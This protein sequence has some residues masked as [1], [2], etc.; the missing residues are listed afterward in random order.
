MSRCQ[1]EQVYRK[2]YLEMRLAYVGAF[3]QFVVQKWSYQLRR[4]RDQFWTGF[5]LNEIERTGFRE[6]LRI[7]VK[8]LNH[9]C[10]FVSQENL[11]DLD[12]VYFPHRV[13]DNRVT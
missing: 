8:I 9:N 3:A 5:D 12:W 11:L 10:D 4:D 7:D 6:D 13:Q 2:M 1:L